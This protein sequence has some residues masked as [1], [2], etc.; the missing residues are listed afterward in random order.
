MRKFIKKSD[1]QYP[2]PCK[3]IAHAIVVAVIPTHFLSKL[4]AVLDMMQNPSTVAVGMMNAMSER[5]D[6]RHGP[7]R[8]GCCLHLLWSHATAA[9]MR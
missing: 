1:I 9:P 4:G 6:P 3:D 2:M 7:P 8:S 5:L